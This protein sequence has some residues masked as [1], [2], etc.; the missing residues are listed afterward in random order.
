MSSYATKANDIGSSGQ[1]R[2]Q[3]EAHGGWAARASWKRGQL[4]QRLERNLTA[5]WGHRAGEA[6]RQHAEN[7]VREE[8]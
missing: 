7:P 2:T 4:E 8:A 5:G 3:E 6:S 1:R